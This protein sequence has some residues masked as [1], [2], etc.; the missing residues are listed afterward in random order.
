[1]SLWATGIKYDT[2]TA[3]A[4]FNNHVGVFELK[5]CYEVNALPPG[6][7]NMNVLAKNTYDSLM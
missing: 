4:S 6:N 7:Q 3:V 1:M 2:G 5:C